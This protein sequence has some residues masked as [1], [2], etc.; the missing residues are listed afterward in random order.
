MMKEYYDC[1]VEGNMIESFVFNN[2]VWG[3]NHYIGVLTTY[4]SNALLNGKG[5]IRPT[6][7]NKINT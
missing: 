6:K 4:K 5:Q 1:L 7:Y 2:Q 3:L